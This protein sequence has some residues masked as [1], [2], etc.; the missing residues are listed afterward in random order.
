MASHSDLDDFRH[1][2]IDSWLLINKSHDVRSILP[3][4]RYVCNNPCPCIMHIVVC[5]NGQSC[6]CYVSYN[7]HTFLHR[8]VFTNDFMSYIYGGYI[9]FILNVIYVIWGEVCIIFHRAVS[10]P[11]KGKWMLKYNMHNTWARVV[12]STDTSDQSTAVFSYCVIPLPLLVDPAYVQLYL[13]RVG[14]W[15]WLHAQYEYINYS[16]NIVTC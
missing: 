8:Y 12:F 1:V 5:N 16:V 4:A 10:H 13:V 15:T 14:F 6:A 11:A 7:M 3:F 9:T 2:T